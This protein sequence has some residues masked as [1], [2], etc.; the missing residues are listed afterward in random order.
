MNGQAGI[1]GPL[2]KIFAD[3]P[4]ATYVGIVK[5]VRFVRPDVAI[6]RAVAGMVP[7]GKADINSAVN[8]VQTLV[9]VK[10]ENRWRISLF[11]NTPAAFHGRP[12]LVRQLSD[13]LRQLLHRATV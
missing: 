12:E 13:E 5:D 6:L 10:H 3:H 11:Q 9:A 1:E 7:P 2:R 4:T 8:A